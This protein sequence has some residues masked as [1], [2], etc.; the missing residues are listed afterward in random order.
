[1][2]TARYEIVLEHVPSLPLSTYFFH[3]SV[4]PTFSEIKKKFYCACLFTFLMAFGHLKWLVCHHQHQHSST[5]ATT[6]FCVFSIPLQAHT[7]EAERKAEKQQFEALPQYLS[8]SHSGAG[9]DSWLLSIIYKSKVY[10]LQ[11]S[12]MIH[13]QTTV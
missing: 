7:P 9:L 6:Q 13:T 2:W 4:I 10:T 1:M 12:Y 11:K 5:P 8:L 3:Q